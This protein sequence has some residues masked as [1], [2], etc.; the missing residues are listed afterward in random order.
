METKKKP[1][2][3]DKTTSL[4]DF[5]IS[6]ASN[7][8]WKCAHC[9]KFLNGTYDIN[10]VVALY[11]NGNEPDSLEALCRNCEDKKTFRKKNGTLRK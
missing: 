11:K 5:V 9:Q 3:W 8:N 1:S 2:K 7:Q 10:H 4:Y 6:L